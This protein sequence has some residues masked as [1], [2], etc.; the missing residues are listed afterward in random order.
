MWRVT[1]GRLRIGLGFRS[2][3]RR[4]RSCIFR[5][6]RMVFRLGNKLSL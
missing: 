3:F 2:G 1:T 6:W 4:W 5:R